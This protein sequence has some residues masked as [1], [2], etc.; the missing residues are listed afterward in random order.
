MKR[1]GLRAKA[2]RKFKATTDSNHNRPVAPNLL[3]QD[4]SAE[5][6]NQKWVGDI[7]YLWTEEGWMY[8]AVVMDLYSRR[9]VGWSL[10]A[11]MQAGLVCDAPQMA[12]W[13]RHMPLSVLVHTDRGVQYCSTAYQNLLE[14]HGLLCSMSA[15]GNC[16]DKGS[17]SYCTSSVAWS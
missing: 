3:A 2:A 7:T 6:P 16:Y 4:F 8:L 13:R 11:R 10:S 14:K 17:I 1:Q 9:V 5:A 12:L 15:Q